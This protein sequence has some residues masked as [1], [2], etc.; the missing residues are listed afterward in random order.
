MQLSV[1]LRE[2]VNNM[3]CIYSERKGIKKFNEIAHLLPEECARRIRI[4][5]GHIELRHGLRQARLELKDV[6]EDCI[7][8]LENEENKK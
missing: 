3:W 2:I 8:M 4:E 1:A 5:I 7:E 6:V